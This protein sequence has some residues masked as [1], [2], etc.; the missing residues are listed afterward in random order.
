MKK[1]YIINTFII[2]FFSLFISFVTL[3][4]HSKWNEKNGKGSSFRFISFRSNKPNALSLDNSNTLQHIRINIQINDNLLYKDIIEELYFDNQKIDLQQAD[5]IG[6]R[7]KT[8]LDVPIG[9]HTITWKVKRFQYATPKVITKKHSLKIR[10]ENSY[11]QILI[12]GIK[13]KTS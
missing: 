9:T 8:Y 12:N 6:M 10:S 11:Q 7:G 4:T 2:V 1:N 3:Q 13:V 5:Q